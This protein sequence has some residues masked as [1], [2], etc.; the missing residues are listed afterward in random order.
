LRKITLAIPTGIVYD[1]RRPGHQYRPR[2]TIAVWFTTRRSSP[3]LV[4]IC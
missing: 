4:L 3:D 2:M 1:A